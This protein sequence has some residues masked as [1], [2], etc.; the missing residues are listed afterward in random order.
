MPSFLKRGDNCARCAK[1]QLSSSAPARRCCVLSRVAAVRRSPSKS[2]LKIAPV[3]QEIA[4]IFILKL[5]L[6]VD[7]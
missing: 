6:R 2:S 4:L 5:I 3:L 1:A 7:Q